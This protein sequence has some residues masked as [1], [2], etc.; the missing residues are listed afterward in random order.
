MA[1]FWCTAA[2]PEPSGWERVENDH[3]LLPGGLGWAPATAFVFL[4]G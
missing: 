4:K 2:L 3:S 1:G